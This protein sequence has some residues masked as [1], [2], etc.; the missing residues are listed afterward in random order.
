[1]VTSG[2][3]SLEAKIAIEAS[4]S[5]NHH[6]MSSVWSPEEKGAGFG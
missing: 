4:H 2:P 1:M 6:E 3:F 5:T